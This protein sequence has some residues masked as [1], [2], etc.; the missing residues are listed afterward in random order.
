MTDIDKGREIL[1]RLQEK[2]V[3]IPCPESV[4]IGADIS[5]ERISGEG[6]EIHTQ[7]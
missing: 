7:T 4:E 5:P 6:V 2:G 3:R 1:K